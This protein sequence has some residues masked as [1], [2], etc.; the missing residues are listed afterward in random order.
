VLFRSGDDQAAAFA[1]SARGDLRGVARAGGFGKIGVDAT[2]GKNMARCIERA[3]AAVA[4]S[5]SIGIV[6]Q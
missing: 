5:P 6:N 3:F 2:S 4:A 1:G